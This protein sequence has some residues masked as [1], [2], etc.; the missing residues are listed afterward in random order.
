M[1]DTDVTTF[2]G[3]GN[4]I[5]VFDHNTNYEDFFGTVIAPNP[6][7]GIFPAGTGVTIDNGG[8]AGG[9]LDGYN[10]YNQDLRGISSQ[11]SDIDNFDI[12]VANNTVA[13]GILDNTSG[14]LSAGTTILLIADNTAP[15]SLTILNDITVNENL[16]SIDA[17]DAFGTLVDFDIPAAPSTPPLGIVVRPP[18]GVIPIASFGAITVAKKSS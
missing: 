12:Y 9:T 14:D 18:A 5:L 1:N 6:S 2:D 15:Q 10:M 16:F 4:D 8:V 7:I 3:G 13:L 11:F 17:A